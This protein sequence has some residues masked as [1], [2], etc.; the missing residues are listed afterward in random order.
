MEYQTQ[1]VCQALPQLVQPS[2]GFVKLAKQGSPNRAVNCV[3]TKVIIFLLNL[4]YY[5]KQI[6]IDF[7]T[8]YVISMF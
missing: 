1:L 7:V 6:S 5:V 2:H 8:Q 3:P 4:K